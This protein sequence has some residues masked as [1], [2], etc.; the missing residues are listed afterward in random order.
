MIIWLGNHQAV[1]H[2]P[3][4]D[5]D[6]TPVIDSRGERVLVRTPIDGKRYTRVEPPDGISFAELVTTLVHPD[7]VWA[8]HSDAETPAWVASTDP[9][10]SAR[11]GALWGC[12]VREPETG[13]P[14]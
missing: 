13:Q 14:A 5:E 8:K 11:L 6:G 2:L 4:T 7:G 1:D 10:L 9:A 12:E 3:G